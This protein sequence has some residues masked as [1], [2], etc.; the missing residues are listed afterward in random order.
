MSEDFSEEN[1]KKDCP[2]CDI[3]SSALRYIL[4]KTKYFYV[5]CDHNPLIEGHILIISKKHSA[6]VG[7]LRGL[8]FE[9]IYDFR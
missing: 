6:C 3:N 4:E 5:V 1:I 8:C 2:Y 7:E 9:G